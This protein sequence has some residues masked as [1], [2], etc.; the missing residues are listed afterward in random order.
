[1]L[2]ANNEQ[3]EWEKSTKS[4]VFIFNG[5]YRFRFDGGFFINTG[6]LLGAASTRYNWDY[7]DPSYGSSD[8]TSREGKDITPFGMLEVTLGIEF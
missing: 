8:E 5:G 7:V 4:I 3:W 1:M 6:A 2:Y